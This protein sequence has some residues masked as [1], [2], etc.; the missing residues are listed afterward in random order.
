LE[1]LTKVYFVRL[2]V[3]DAD[4]S[5]PAARAAV[6]VKLG[7]ISELNV[8]DD[9]GV[10]HFKNTPIGKYQAEVRFYGVRVDISEVQIDASRM[11]EL[12]AEGIIDAD[13]KVLDSDRIPL[14]SGVVE[15]TET[16]AGQAKFSADIV[17]GAA[18]F[19]NIPASTYRLTATYLGL[20]A[21]DASVT[22]TL[23][24]EEKV[25][26]T[27]V[28]YLTIVVKR[29][30]DTFLP[31]AL[32]RVAEKTRELRS[33][34]TNEQGETTVR[35][36]KG[37]FLATVSF[38]GVNVASSTIALRETRRITLGA[39][40][41][42][43]SVRLVDVSEAPIT[44]AVINLVRDGKVIITATTNEEGQADFYAA[45]GTYNWTTIIGETPYASTYVSKSNKNL[46]ILHVPGDAQGQAAVL[47]SVAAVSVTSVFGLLRVSRPRAKQRP[48]RPAS[49]ERPEGTLKRPRV[50]RI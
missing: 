28:Y 47:G 4:G 50:P 18:R 3:L 17:D 5:T 2:K 44:G 40:V 27:D 23:D 1:I 34:N 36:P 25:V 45:S 26:E 21:K 32:V 9:Q 33:S 35:L 48:G 7:D 20:K 22:F 29:A 38:Q 37:D 12:V 15:L 24:G 19:E 39:E 11:I 42:R 10:A 46:T 14:D 31:G 41:Y 49:G 30:D 43:V 16:T 13:L 6:Q 8:T